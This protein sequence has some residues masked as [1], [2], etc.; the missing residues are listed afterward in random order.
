MTAE[1]EFCLYLQAAMDFMTI[2]ETR[3]DRITA[4]LDAAILRKDQG[5]SQPSRQLESEWAWRPKASPPF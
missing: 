2:G 4:R 5:G 3:L 1:K